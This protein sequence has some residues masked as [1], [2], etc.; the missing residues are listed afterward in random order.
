MNFYPTSRNAA[1]VNG[2]PCIITKPI[3]TPIPIELGFPLMMSQMPQMVQQRVMFEQT[4]RPCTAIVNNKGRVN[5]DEGLFNIARGYLPTTKQSDIDMYDEL[6]YNNRGYYP[7][8]KRSNTDMYNELNNNNN[9]RG[10]YP[11]TKQN[12]VLLVKTGKSQDAE[13]IYITMEQNKFVFQTKLPLKKQDYVVI[14]NLDGKREN[15]VTYLNKFDFYYLASIEN[16]YKKLINMDLKIVC[17]VSN[18]NIH[19]YKKSY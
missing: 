1:Y 17:N 15:L 16:M 12:D 8:T 6:N 2:K 9:N 14:C 13:A 4:T 5:M 7:S 10:Y 3:F 11:S 18:D 19:Y